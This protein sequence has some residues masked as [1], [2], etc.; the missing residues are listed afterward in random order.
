VFA[1]RQAVFHQPA[2]FCACLQRSIPH[3]VAVYM[4][5]HH[6]VVSA[7]RAVTFTIGAI[8]SH[9][10]DRIL[11][12]FSLMLTLLG[13]GQLFFGAFPR[14]VACTRPVRRFRCLDGWTGYSVS[15]HTPLPIFLPASRWS[16]FSGGVWVLIG[17]IIMEGAAMSLESK[18]LFMLFY[19]YWVLTI[20]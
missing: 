13:C 19:I 1:P 10:S 3:D 2:A 11:T 7:W 18:V 17:T 4:F 16:F 12:A 14:W 15:C 6:I 20:P 5:F 9:I 8:S